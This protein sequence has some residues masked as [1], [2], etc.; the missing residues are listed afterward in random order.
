MRVKQLLPL[1]KNDLKVRIEIL[2][3]CGV[4]ETFS[5]SVKD[6]FSNMNKLALSD[7]LVTLVEIDQDVIPSNRIIIH[8]RDFDK[9]E[10]DT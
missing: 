7:L 2:C 9:L 3:A 5:G 1:I 6:V 10:G 8:A 4:N